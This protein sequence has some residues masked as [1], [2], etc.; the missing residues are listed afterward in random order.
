MRESQLF[1]SSCLTTNLRVLLQLPTEKHREH[2]YSRHR[3]TTSP[4]QWHLQGPTTTLG[5]AYNQQL[6]NKNT[7][8][9]SGTHYNQTFF[10]YLYQLGPI[11]TKRQCQC[12]DHFA[13]TLAILFPLKSMET[14]EMGC[15]PIL[16]RHR[17][18]VTALTLTLSVSGPI[19]IFSNMKRCGRESRMVDVT[20]LISGIQKSRKRSSGANFDCLSL[21]YFLC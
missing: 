2:S 1:Y 18:V 9:I 10:K 7:L 15:K 3:S 17:R 14:F 13:M 21:V 6:N 5:P 16:E 8:L 11:Y 20:E 12:C 19:Q 4:K